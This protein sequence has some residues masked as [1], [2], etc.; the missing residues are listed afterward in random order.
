MVDDQFQLQMCEIKYCLVNIISRQIWS[1]LIRSVSGSLICNLHDKISVS[2]LRLAAN[3]IYPARMLYGVNTGTR[4]RKLATIIRCLPFN[5]TYVHTKLK[6]DRRRYFVRTYQSR[7]QSVHCQREQKRSTYLLETLLADGLRV[8]LHLEDDGVGLTDE[9]PH[10]R[11]RSSLGDLRIRVGLIPRRAA[12]RPLLLHKNQYALLSRRAS[13]KVYKENLDRDVSDNNNDDDND[14]PSRSGYAAGRRPVVAGDTF[15]V[16][17][18]LQTLR[19]CAAVTGSR[20]T[21]TCDVGNVFALVSETERV[22]SASI[23]RRGMAHALTV[24]RRRGSV[25]EIESFSGRS[26]EWR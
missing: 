3:L 5:R 7:Y 25:G 19:T 13:D 22:S 24:R 6:S 11:D 16:I 23:S 17:T 21:T 4:G 15:F 20:A 9:A 14:G 26:I 8:D 2:Y 12:R 10:L 1:P 18:K